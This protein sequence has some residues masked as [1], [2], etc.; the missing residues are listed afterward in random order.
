M[1]K[2]CKNFNNLRFYLWFPVREERGV[3]NALHCF[4]GF[5]GTKCLISD[6]HNQ[7]NSTRT[8]LICTA[9]WEWQKCI[10][11][12]KKNILH[13]HQNKIADILQ[14][15]AVTTKTGEKIKFLSP[16]FWTFSF[17]INSNGRI[18]GCQI[19]AWLH[20]MWAVRDSSHGQARQ[21][22]RRRWSAIGADEKNKKKNNNFYVY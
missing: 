21:N 2:I 5:G 19:P 20:I 11:R 8:Y 3:L 18:D 9:I 1:N 10:V 17:L 13:Q 12:S 16:K 22:A 7:R 6:V 14:N 4:H 15:I